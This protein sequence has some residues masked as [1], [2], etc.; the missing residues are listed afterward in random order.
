[1]REFL[2]RWRRTIAL[3][4]A[5][6]AIVTLLRLVL[7]Q[8][9][10]KPMIVSA[11]TIAP[12]T[13]ITADKVTVKAVPLAALPP[14]TYQKVSQVVGQRTAVPIAAGTPLFPALFSSSLF[15]RK[16]HKGQVI[17]ALPLRE[18]D[19]GLASSGDEVVFFLT[20]QQ[21]SNSPTSNNSDTKNPQTLPEETIQKAPE[22]KGLSTQITARVLSVSTASS[23]LTG[24]QK[25]ATIEVAVNTKHAPLLVQ[26]SKTEPLQLARTG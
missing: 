20:D 9:V 4:A 16:A 14:R 11:T 17:L 24:R 1:M 21:G 7:P 5:V 23:S 15:A 2:W 25:A 3:A 12:G 26:A 10:S 19:Q 6:A 18:S 22:S 13:V 8:V